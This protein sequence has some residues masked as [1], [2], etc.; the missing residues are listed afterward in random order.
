MDSI[1]DI[2]VASTQLTTDNVDNLER[3]V[4]QIHKLN[5]ETT[6]AKTINVAAPFK[7][8]IEAITGQTGAVTA[9]AN[10]KQQT[11]VVMKLN[12]REFGKAVID[13]LNDRGTSN[14]VIK[15]A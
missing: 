10:A 1:K 9:A 15:K 12:D 8:L 5:V 11:N 14:T 6:I 13:V 4:N 2:A 7:E 3:V